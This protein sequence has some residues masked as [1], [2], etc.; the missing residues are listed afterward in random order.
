MVESIIVCKHGNLGYSASL[1][2]TDETLNVELSHEDREKLYK[3]ITYTVRSSH[4]SK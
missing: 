2:F 3:M 1:R 4:V